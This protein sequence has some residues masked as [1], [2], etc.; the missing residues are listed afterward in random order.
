MENRTVTSI[1]VSKALDV[2]ESSTLSQIFSGFLLLLLAVIVTVVATYTDSSLEVFQVILSWEN[3]IILKAVISLLF[4]FNF[5]RLVSYALSSFESFL[6]S[7]RPRSEPVECI[8]G[9]PRVELLDHLFTFG[10]FKREEVEKKWSIPRYRVT[11]LSKKLEEVGV[12]VRGENN[13]RVLNTE[14]SRA[15]VSSILDGKK[16]AEELRPLMRK[17][18]NG[19]SHRPS[20]REIA[21]RVSPFVTR[22]LSEFAR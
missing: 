17:V 8:D 10:T 14:F 22:P 9:I 21:D 3:K 19:F 13:G 12:L 16:A 15:D 1:L 5:S 20:A 7:A 6:E 4:V 11:E 18:E 2:L